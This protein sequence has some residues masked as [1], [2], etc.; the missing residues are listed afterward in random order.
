ML[1][2]I[3][4][5]NSECSIKIGT[6]RIVTME[7][8]KR[9]MREKAFSVI[10]EVESEVMQDKNRALR[11]LTVPADDLEFQESTKKAY[12]AVL[13]KVRKQMIKLECPDFFKK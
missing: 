4:R 1:A 2:A 6:Q 7:C 3:K 9:Q 10:Y 11:D 12:K 8:G 13:K 5:V